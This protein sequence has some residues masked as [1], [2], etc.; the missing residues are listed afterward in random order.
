MR[1]DGFCAPTRKAEGERDDGVRRRE[2]KTGQIA[3]TRTPKSSMSDAG[4]AEAARKRWELENNVVAME[5]S[6]T[7]A[8]GG[9]SGAATTSAAGAGPSGSVAPSNQ[10]HNDLW[11]YDVDVQ[12]DIATAAPWTKDPHYFKHVR[13]SALA[14]LKMTIHTRSG[15]N[16]EVMGMLQ[17]KPV[18]DTIVV[19]DAFVLPVEGTETRVNAQAEAYEYMVEYNQRSKESG[20]HENVVGWYHSHPGYGCWLSGIDVNT[21]KLNQEYQEPFIAIVI[22]PIRTQA[23]GKVDIGCFRTYPRDYKPPE[24]PKVGGRGGGAGGGG[25]GR[26]PLSKVEDYGVHAKQYYSLDVSYFKSELDEHLMS[27]L[28]TQYWMRTLSSSA[29]L[30][31]EYLA[32]QVADLAAKVEQAGEGVAR[33]GRLGG[34]FRKGHGANTQL[35]GIARDGAQ[36]ALEQVHGIFSQVVKDRLFNGK[37]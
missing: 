34:M 18:G 26:V 21:Q 36:I 4:G 28:W 25:G 29:N 6:P 27:L 37:A 22:D 1:S 16:I 35:A 30:T 2:G 8:A 32:G 24:D 12:R 3:H 7:A 14:L 31:S 17:G 20:R 11:K 10:G 9:S 13:V 33:E 15:G 23:A 19:I 5:D